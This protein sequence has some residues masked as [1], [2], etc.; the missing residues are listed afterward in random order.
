M[1]RLLVPNITTSLYNDVPKDFAE[2]LEPQQFGSISLLNFDIKLLSKILG[3][4]INKHLQAL[5]HK[6]KVGIV[7]GHQAGD[8]VHK[9]VHLIH[10]LQWYCRLSPLP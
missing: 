8:N 10:H 3:T 1:R 2:G 5:I 4:H 9:T 6:D 7:S